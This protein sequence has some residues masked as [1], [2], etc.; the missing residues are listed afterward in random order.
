MRLRNRIAIVTGAG[1]GLG[2]AGALAFAAEGA[3]VVA[4]DLDPARGEETAALVRAAGGEAIAIPAD[5]S[6][7][8]DARALVERT[9]ATLGGLDVLYNNAGIAPVGRDGFTPAIAEDDWDWVIR[10]N[11]TSVFLCCKYAIPLLANRPGA[12]IVNTAS[13]MAHLPLGLTDAYAA[14]KAGVANLTRSMAPGCAQLG[15]RVNALSPGYVDTPM[16]ALIFGNEALREAFA[17]DH[18]S[19]LQPPEDVARVAV[20]LASDDAAGVTGAV[21]NCDRGWTAFKRPSLLG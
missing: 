1:S 16:N 7:R 9:V 11:L 6:Q 4:S 3:R 13:S 10:V 12:A 14:S 21:I 5:V 20:F 2:R 19:G 17:R 8:A 18:A 15:I